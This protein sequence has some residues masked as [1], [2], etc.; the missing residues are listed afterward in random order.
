MAEA[1]CGHRRAYHVVM[2]AALGVASEWQSRIAYYRYKKLRAA[3]ICS[4]L[5]NFTRLLSTPGARPDGLVDIMPTIVVEQL[6]G[7]F[8]DACDHGYGAMNKPWALRQLTRHRAFATMEDYLFI[9]EPDELLLRPLPNDASE[10]QPVAFAFFNL[11]YKHPMYRKAGVNHVRAAM[12]RYA[13][14]GDVDAVQHVAI[15]PAIVHK[16][17]LADT[18]IEPWWRLSLM[19]TLRVFFH[20]HFHIS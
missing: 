17:L 2:T 20:I 13:R 9:V 10:A 5:G 4:D 8:C 15:S 11:D 16:R 18:I 6:S 7:G 14:G 1:A 19:A 12:A 3:N